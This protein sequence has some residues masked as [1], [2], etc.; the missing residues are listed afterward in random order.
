MLPFW[1]QGALEKM[2]PKAADFL[3]DPKAVN[4][5]RKQQYRARRPG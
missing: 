2:K 3:V 4:V 1:P 5:M